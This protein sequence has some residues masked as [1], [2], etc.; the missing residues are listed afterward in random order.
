LRISNGIEPGRIRHVPHVLY[1]W[2]S[3]HGSTAALP[4]NKTYATGAGMKALEDHFAS[5]TSG[6]RIEPGPIPTVYRVRRP[7]PDHPPLVSVLMPTRDGRQVLDRAIA[8]VL[9]KT[10]YPR[11]ELVVIDN[12]SRDPGTLASLQ[13]LE[14]SG[15]GRV[16]RYDRPFNF[17]SINNFAVG[18]ARGEVVVLLNDDVAVIEA[19]W[20]TE[21]A[22]QAIQPGIGCVGAKLLYPDDTVQHAG[23]LLG[24]YGVAGHVFRGIPRDAQGYF[25]RALLPQNL[26]AVTG[27]CMA[28]RKS[29]YQEVGGLDEQN[30]PVAFNDIDFCIRVREAGYRNVWTPYA[31][32]YHHESVSRGRE[33]TPEKRQRFARECEYMK[34]RWGRVLLEDPFYNPNLSL[35]SEQMEL[36]WPP[37]AAKP[38]KTTR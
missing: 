28:V 24:L 12:Q 13:E 4:A 34:R 35:Q 33:D 21:L 36:A 18:L 14:R 38:W 16:I 29:I 1:H 19:D 32:L 10:T 8:T 15:R 37:R 6:I 27:A 5:A 9:Q 17:S 26:S 11:F 20:L 3:I 7:V 23:V 30:L 2:R 22:T 31:L 25:A